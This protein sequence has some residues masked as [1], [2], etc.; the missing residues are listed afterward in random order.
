M[1]SS[2]SRNNGYCLSNAYQQN[3]PLISQTSYKNNNNVLHNNLRENILS[4]RVETYSIFIDGFHRSHSSHKNPFKFPI[5]FG[6]TGDNEKEY[7]DD[8]DKETKVRKYQGDTGVRFVE[9]F[10]NVKFL[11]VQNIICPKYTKINYDFSNKKFIYDT[12]DESNLE[13]STRYIVFRLDDLESH[14]RLT[15][16]HFLKNDSFIL[17]FDKNMGSDSML[18]IPINRDVVDF[19]DSHLEN[20]S[21]INISVYNDVDNI[22]SLPTLTYTDQTDSTLKSVEFNFDTI[23][24]NLNSIIDNINSSSG[25]TI[26]PFTGVD[27]DISDVKNT[28]EQINTLKR[29]HQIQINLDIGIIENEMG[30]HTNYEK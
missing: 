18:L 10:N 24:T 2:T 14:K 25:N 28:I 19:K 9:H 26:N 15:S 21:R 23:I 30:V 8:I 20:L 11:R 17:R 16:G 22:L 13:L 27:G 5:N 4:E 12:D 3:H 6:S 29:K 7:W 1:L